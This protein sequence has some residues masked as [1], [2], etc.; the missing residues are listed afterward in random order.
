MTNWLF[1]LTS[2]INP[3]YLDIFSSLVDWW[4][5]STNSGD[6][7]PAKLQKVTEALQNAAPYLHY[8]DFLGRI[9]NQTKWYS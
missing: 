4:Q 7:D 5:K 8:D 9:L 2:F 1:Y 6:Y 3:E